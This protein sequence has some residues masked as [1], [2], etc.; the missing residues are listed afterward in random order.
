MWRHCWAVADGRVDQ[1]F[2]SLWVARHHFQKPLTYIGFGGT[3]KQVRDV[4]HVD[5]LC[6]LISMHLADATAWD[7]RVYTVGGGREVS[8]SLLELTELC[9]QETGHE[10]PVASEPGT[11]PMD[12]RI[13]LSD[14]ATVSHDTGWKP[15]RGVREIVAD[16]AHWIEEN[17][18]TL[19]PIF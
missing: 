9:R 14:C 18:S 15:R 11:S 13:Y 2:L 19:R 1:G 10:V 8:T 7:G 4:L 12:L 16:T 3:G 6:D 17:E 5:D